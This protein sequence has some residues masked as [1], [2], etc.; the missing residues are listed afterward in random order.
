MEL[1]KVQIDSCMLF[2]RNFCSNLTK[3]SFFSLCGQGPSKK[4]LLLNICHLS[5]GKC[6][7]YIV[8]CKTQCAL[9][10]FCFAIY[11]DKSGENWG[12]NGKDATSI[13]DAKVEGASLLSRDLD[14]SLWYIW[15][16]KQTWWRQIRSFHAN[17][18]G[19]VE[20]PCRKAI[21]LFRGWRVWMLQLGTFG[22]LWGKVSIEGVRG[23]LPCSPKF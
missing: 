1:S 4:K 22:F 23:V 10:F 8:A 16:C 3:F 14:T 18:V 20:S 11:G 9:F 19:R 2:N 15:L 7:K 13:R 5:L 17:M 12:K 21:F 6:N